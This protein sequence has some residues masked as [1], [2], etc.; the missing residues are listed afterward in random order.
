LSGTSHSKYS[1]L[2][3]NDDE[4]SPIRAAC[5]GAKHDVSKLLLKFFGFRCQ[6]GE[7]RI[8][9][10]H[11]QSFFETSEQASCP[12]WGAFGNIGKDFVKVMM[13]PSE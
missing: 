7:K 12:F 8:F 3:T 2:I 6:R 13:C 9:L 11:H 10:K 1:Y 4:Q 5:P